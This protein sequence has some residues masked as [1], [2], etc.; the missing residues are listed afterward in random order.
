MTSEQD[1]VPEPDVPDLFADPHLSMRLDGFDCEF[2]RPDGE[3]VAR[4]AWSSGPEKQMNLDLLRRLWA[5]QRAFVGYSEFFVSDA[6][7][8]ERLHL[9]RPSSTGSALRV[10]VMDAHGRPLGHAVGRSA[11]LSQRIDLLAPDG[12]A[13]GHLEARD[14]VVGYDPAGRRVAVASKDLGPPKPFS[15]PPTTMNVRFVGEVPPRLRVL[16]V[17]GLLGWQQTA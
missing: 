16:F 11:G 10:D 6:E 5:G 14:H 12:A 17:A 1:S 9:V 4:A 7:G 8:V 15:R 2:T 13:T 3:L